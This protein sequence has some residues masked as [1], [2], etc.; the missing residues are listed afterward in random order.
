M[1]PTEADP[2]VSASP[3]AAESDGDIDLDVVELELRGL[4]RGYRSALE[5][6]SD[7]PSFGPSKVS[8][9]RTPAEVSSSEGSSRLRFGSRFWTRVYVETHVRKRLL[10]IGDCLRLR[11]LDTT[12]ADET[13]RLTALADEL[14]AQSAPLFRWR[15]LTG[16]VSRLPPVAAAVP[17]LS[18]AASWPLAGEVTRKALLEAFLVLAAT[19]FVLW[20]VVVWPSIRFGFRI[21]RVIFT[22]K[23]RQF[24]L[25][26]RMATWHGFKFP[27]YDE[28]GNT[29]EAQLKKF[30]TEN[31]YWA[32]NRV[33]GALKRRKPA[34][35]PLDL[36][37]NF[38]FYVW[39]AYSIFYFWGLVDAITTH[40]LTRTLDKP[41]SWVGLVLAGGLALIPLV[42]PV[43]A[44][45]TYRDRPH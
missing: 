28:L 29:V 19:A 43:R 35:A 4:L 20:I 11:L 36:L 26:N 38:A 45:K 7:M 10:A 18:S 9:P 22:G 27:A 30:P 14:E 37:L 23:G 24:G 41:S 25:G 16:L 1:R 33:Y 5:Y 40:T 17:V 6:A 32:E 21:K 13:A 44:W 12:N 3:A 8:V 2:A 15:R 42:Y 31:L 34:E 39:T